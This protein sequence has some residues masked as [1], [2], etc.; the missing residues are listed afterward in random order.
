MTKAVLPPRHVA[1]NVALDQTRVQ[2]VEVNVW[3]STSAIQDEGFVPRD[4]VHVGRHRREG[5]LGVE[6]L[7]I[8]LRVGSGH[9]HDKNPW[10]AGGIR[11]LL[12]QTRSHFSEHR[13]ATQVADSQVP[14]DALRRF[15]TLGAGH[16]AGCKYDQVE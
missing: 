2:S 12:P 16:D 6:I 11:A 15:C 10:L 3:I 7:D 9:A 14:L 5:L 1:S 13:Q 4:G 8:P